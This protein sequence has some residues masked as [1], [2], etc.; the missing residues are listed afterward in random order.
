M[1]T[2][3][4]LMPLLLLTMTTFSFICFCGRASTTVA[5]A[6]QAVQED[7]RLVVAKVNGTSIYEEQLNQ[8]LQSILGKFKK[9]GKREFSPELLRLKREQVLNQLIDTTLIQ[10]ASQAFKV[11]D[12]DQKVRTRI[13]EIRKGPSAS[14]LEGRSDAELRE[15][16]RGQ[17]L[18]DEYLEQ[19]GI[20]RPVVPEKDIKAYYAKN[21]VSF[22][23]QESVKVRHILVKTGEDATPEEKERARAKID[24]VRQ[25]ILGGKA[26]AEV[27]AEHSECDSAAAG[28]D[29]GYIEK[30][31]MPPEF[32]RV[33]FSPEPGGLSEIVQ[34]KFGYHVLEVTD[35]KPESVVPYDDKVKE[36]IEKFL[37]S[38]M[39]RQ[40]LATHIRELR[41]QARI[42][43]FVQ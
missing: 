23:A 22:T 20:A 14:K 2:G 4:K 13:G 6:A 36:F 15:S 33:A 37:Q 1:R 9:F 24:R 3:R 17:I 35:M 31:F 21:R 27:A 28:G 25:M 8:Q 39:K 30:G 12:V 29:L 34:T 5:G 41:E 40:K 26:F 16:I 10:Q 32:D 43:I 19:N 7:G 11:D 38:E 18:M 42:E